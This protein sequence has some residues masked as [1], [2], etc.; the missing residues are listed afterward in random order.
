MLWE[1]EPSNSVAS[2]CQAG[3]AKHSTGRPRAGK[4][5]FVWQILLIGRQPDN[6]TRATSKLSRNSGASHPPLQEA[7]PRP[8]G[9]VHKGGLGTVK[10]DFPVV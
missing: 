2:S 7:K 8:S 4:D 10:Q 5:P 6:L 1:G 3:G 9:C